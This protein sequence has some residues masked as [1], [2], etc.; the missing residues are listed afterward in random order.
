MGTVQDRINQSVTSLS[1]DSDRM[2]VF[3]NGDENQDYTDKNGRLV[4]SLRKYLA[5]ML[6]YLPSPAAPPLVNLI[7]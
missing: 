6:G 5:G 3:I 2:K 4:P 1:E 7:F